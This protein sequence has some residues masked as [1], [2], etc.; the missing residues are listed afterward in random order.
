V[1][2]STGCKGG[3]ATLKTF[4]SL[5]HFLGADPFFVKQFQDGSLKP[6]QTQHSASI[7]LQEG[8]S[9]PT[10]VLMRLQIVLQILP[11][12][13]IG[14]FLT[15]LSPVFLPVMW[16]DAEAKITED[17]ASQLKVVGL[18]PTI[19]EPIGIASILIGL[20]LIFV[21]IF[22]K[23]RRK[24]RKQIAEKKSEEKLDKC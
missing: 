2:N 21:L 7:S 14:S 10:E 15:N 12:P 5:P 4:V 8:T 18:M 3:D 16:F 13:N 9:I 22:M 6:N 23:V 19:V 17:I 20:I 11:N 24:S 1:Q